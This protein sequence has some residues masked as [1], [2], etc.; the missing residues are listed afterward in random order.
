MVGQIVGVW[1]GEFGRQEATA[2]LSNQFA[3][4]VAL[5][6]PIPVE[7]LGMFAPMHHFVQHG[8]VILG[9]RELLT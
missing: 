4:G 7:P 3:H 5:V 1:D 8:L 6:G 2:H 9:G